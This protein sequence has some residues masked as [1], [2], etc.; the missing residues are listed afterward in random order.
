MRRDIDDDTMVYAA[1]VGEQNCEAS[2]TVVGFS[3]TEVD[4]YAERE[5][6]NCA[7]Y[8]A[9]MCWIT[10]PDGTERE[11]EPEDFPHW[12]TDAQEFKLGEVLGA[13]DY[14]NVR[15][16]ARDGLTIVNRN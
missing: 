1:S 8:D 6:R 7:R 10:L 13:E 4:R 9:E 11:A 5:Q 2:V 14:G 16:L 15:E 3:P 12:R